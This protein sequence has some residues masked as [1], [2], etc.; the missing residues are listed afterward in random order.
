MQN[1]NGLQPLRHLSVY[2]CDKISLPV[3]AKQ[4]LNGEISFERRS[5]FKKNMALLAAVLIVIAIFRN[6]LRCN[7]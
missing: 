4:R 7:Y 5:D 1:S 6:S 3:S 2:I